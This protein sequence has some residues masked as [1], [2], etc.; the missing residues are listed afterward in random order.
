MKYFT[1]VCEEQIKTCLGLSTSN[2]FRLSGDTT[3]DLGLEHKDLRLGPT[4]MK[5]WEKTPPHYLSR[6]QK[7]RTSVFSSCENWQWKFGFIQNTNKQPVTH[8]PAFLKYATKSELPMVLCCR[9][10]TG[11]GGVLPVGKP[12][13]SPRSFLIQR[14]ALCRTGGGS[15]GS[16][17]AEGSALPG[18][19]ATLRRPTLE[20]AH[21]EWAGILI[22]SEEC[23]T[24]TDIH[25]YKGETSSAFKIRRYEVEMKT[26]FVQPGTKELSVQ[27]FYSV[28][29]YSPLLLT[30]CSPVCCSPSFDWVLTFFFYSSCILLMLLLHFYSLVNY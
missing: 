6:N 20:G 9:W 12:C 11:L 22:R 15:G 17:T 3:V 27:R 24:P 25:R 28:V 18:P 23:D 1:I 19:A 29:L 30:H 26:N 16:H 21:R 7:G 10:T 14:A 8:R 2:S 4:C 13:P 5:H